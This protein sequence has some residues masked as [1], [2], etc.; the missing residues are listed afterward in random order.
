MRHPYK[1][2][3]IEATYISRMKAEG[4]KQEV[5]DKRQDGEDGRREG[6]GRT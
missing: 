1:L 4:R 5:Q 3:R 6:E 2:H